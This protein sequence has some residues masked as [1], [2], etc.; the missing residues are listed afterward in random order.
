VAGLPPLSFSGGPSASDATSG[1][2]RNRTY[3]GSFSFK[4]GPSL[5]QQALPLVAVG[6]LAWLILKK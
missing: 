6:A 3:T 4:S 1:G 2:G 5:M